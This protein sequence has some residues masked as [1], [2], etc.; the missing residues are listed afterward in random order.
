MREGTRKSRAP[1]GEDAVRIGVCELEEA[2]LRHAPADR[3]DDAEPLHDVLVQ[4]LAPQIEEAVLQPQIFRV[5]GLAEHRQ[6]QLLGRRQHLDLGREQLDLA[7]RQVGV[8]GALGA[9][10]H[11]AVDADHPLGA[12]ASRPS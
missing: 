8:H 9:R 4:G 10:A 6:R 12:H 7:G 11:L 3:G 1:S 2:G 5:V